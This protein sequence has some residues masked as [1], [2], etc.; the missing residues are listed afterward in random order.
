MTNHI[1]RKA[2]QTHIVQSELTPTNNEKPVL[3]YFC[4]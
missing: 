1:I 3:I 2:L 4:F